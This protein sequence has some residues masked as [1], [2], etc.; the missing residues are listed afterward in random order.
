MPK[1]L[2]VKNL[3]VSFPSRRQTVEAVRGLSFSMD[4]EKIG[5]V[6]ESGSCKSVT[7]R[8]ILGLVRPPGV[9]K[10]DKI[11]FDGMDLLHADKH[12]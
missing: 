8:A 7:G 3:R 6:G 12:T 2:E 11:A 5:I 9:V 4:R 10:A 1:L